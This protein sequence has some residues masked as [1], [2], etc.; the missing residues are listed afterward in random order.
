MFNKKNSRVIVVST[1]D[2]IRMK[3]IGSSLKI[4]GIRTR[5]FSMIFKNRHMIIVTSARNYQYP[6]NLS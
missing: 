4:S 1:N 3:L 6:Q 2:V 5:Y